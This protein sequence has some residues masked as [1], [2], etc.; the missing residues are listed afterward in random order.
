[1]DCISGSF[2]LTPGSVY[3][4]I[5]I[6]FCFTAS[7]WLPSGYW[8]SVD[9]SKIKKVSGVTQEKEAACQVELTNSLVR[10]IS[11]S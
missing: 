9:A 2:P 1:M 6:Y 8:W 5:V 10:E 11:M 3:E 7:S 4:A